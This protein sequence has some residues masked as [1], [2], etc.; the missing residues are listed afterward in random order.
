M[1]TKI[2]L[3]GYAK[4]IYSFRGIETMIQENLP[5]MW[6]YWSTTRPS[7]YKSYSCELIQNNDGSII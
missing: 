2:I 7:N 1:M 3:Y 4:K 6:S 5:A